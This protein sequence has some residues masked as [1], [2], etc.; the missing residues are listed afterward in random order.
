[1]GGDDAFYLPTSEPGVFT[2]TGSTVGP[3]DP[4]LQH[5]GPPS[6]LLARAAET[7]ES[8]WPGTV[9]RMAVEILGPVP[10]AEVTVRSAVT[11]PGR[12]VELI[13]AELVAGGR[14]AAKARAWRIRTSELA[15][16]DTVPAPEPPPTLPEAGEPVPV[17][18]APFLEA[19]ELRSAV[20][21]WME[22]G[23]ASCWFRQQIPL[24]AGEEPSG[25]QRL[26]AVADCGNGLSN[27]LP[28]EGWM[29]I[30]PDLTVH[31]E[32]YPEGEWIC[33]EAATAIDPGGFGLARST[34]YDTRGAVAR[35]A[36]SLFVGAR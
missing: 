26:M 12:S 31:L 36:Q 33:L 10:V 19:M 23:A 15:L 3:W 9:V 16:P 7:T 2:S 1:M 5:G 29:F 25:L 34:L 32:R 18:K 4:T 30:N 22:P 14:P 13:E 21:S 11:R 28:F 20:G 24:V 8:A 27:V 17:F 35:G 6:A